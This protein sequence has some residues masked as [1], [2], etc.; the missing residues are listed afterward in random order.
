MPDRGKKNDLRD[1]ITNF[2]ALWKMFDRNYGSF[3]P[4]RIDWDLLYR[5]YRPKVTSRTSD[6]ELFEIMSLL[7]EHLNDNH[8]KIQSRRPRR[9]FRSGILGNLNRDARGRAIPIGYN[10]PDFSL[11]LVKEK[12]LRGRFK[13][14]LPATKLAA[15]FGGDFPLYTF[16]RL[17]KDIGYFHI[18]NFDE[19]ERTAA[20]ADEIVTEFR[21][22]RGLIVDIR[23]NGGG[24]DPVA[25]AIA[26]RFADTRRLYMVTRT[27]N[28]PRHDDF[29]PPRYWYTEPK[30]PHPFTKP[31]I[32]LTHRWS[33]S[34][35]DCFALAMRELPRVTNLG[36]FTSGAYSDEYW[37]TLPNGWM[38]SVANK[39]YLDA[40]GRSWEGIGTPPDIRLVNTR[41]D[42]AAGR[43]R[44]LE[45]AMELLIAGPPRRRETRSVPPP[46]ESLAES[47][48]KN[49]PS[50]GIRKA[51]DLYSR[52]KR[53]DSITYY[54]DREEMDILGRNLLSGEMADEAV[55]VL[56]LNRRE[57]PRD[58]HVY[59]SLAE[60][61]RKK[62]EDRLARSHYRKAVELNPNNLPEERSDL[63]RSLEAGHR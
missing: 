49:I 24:W 62:G 9:F 47:L 18:R 55:A 1:P 38:V 61:F 11:D 25:K 19:A 31:V 33:I 29:T 26:D 36:E 8:V 51:L 23:G 52:A 63:K 13:E 35:A 60:A 22:A 15:Y 27:R 39:L 42:I 40:H 30:G 12:Y 58:Y 5:V 2:D 48:E 41:E 20:V 50:L 37:D 56:M 4:K 59:Q 21:K 43:D 10:I 45:A 3:T 44:V 34:A 16:G 46:R 54:V 17:K 57:F 28:G 53:R 32:L 7:L 6:D 14:R